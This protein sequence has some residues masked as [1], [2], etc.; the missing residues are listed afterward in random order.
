M[1]EHI[2]ADLPERST[3]MQRLV[4][5]PFGKSVEIAFKSI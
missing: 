4:V 5:L 3:R 2:F 1:K